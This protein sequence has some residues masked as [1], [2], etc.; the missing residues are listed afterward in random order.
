MLRSSVAQPKVLRYDTYKITRGGAKLT[1]SNP[2]LSVSPSQQAETQVL[3]SLLMF[4]RL[5]L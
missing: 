3:P 2:S 1:C 5:L 4:P